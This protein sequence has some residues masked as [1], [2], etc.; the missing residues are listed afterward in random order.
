MH[1]VTLLR[2]TLTISYA[3]SVTF[4]PGIIFVIFHSTAWVAYNN[5]FVLEIMSQSN[6]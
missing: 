1:K 5:R 2:L 6:D 3:I 4:L